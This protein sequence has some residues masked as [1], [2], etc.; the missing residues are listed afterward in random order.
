MT[1]VDLSATLDWQKWGDNSGFQYDYSER[2]SFYKQ[3]WLA[4]DRTLIFIVYESNAGSS[5]LEIEE[6]DRIV[7]SITVNRS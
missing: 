2:G 6:I 5:E 7:T 1:N 3:W 4:N